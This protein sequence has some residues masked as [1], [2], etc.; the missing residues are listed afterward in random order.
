MAV[1]VRPGT[2][3]HSMPTS[4]MSSAVPS[5]P[6][7]TLHGYLFALVVLVPAWALSFASNVWLGPPFSALPFVMAIVLAAGAG[8][9]NP[10]L[11]ASFITL[12]IVYLNVRSPN[13][14]L[15]VSRGVL[16]LVFLALLG[17]MIS[18]L[19]EMLHRYRREAL[20]QARFCEEAHDAIFAWELEG[21]VRYWNRAADELY[22]FNR[23]LFAEVKATLLTTGQWLGELTHR[24]SDGRE[25][26]V[27]SRM[28]LIRDGAELTVVEADR[29]V[30]ERMH[31]LV[32]LREADRRK[33]EFL[34]TLAHEIRNPLAPIRNELEIMRVA[35]ADPEVV[36]RSRAVMERQLAHL[37]HLVDDLMD[38][39]R[40]TRGKLEL[41]RERLSLDA[42]LQA[43]LETS[44][45][46]IEA[47]HHSFVPDMPREPLYVL[48]DLTR[49]AQLFSN[50][51]NNAAKYTP[52]GGRITLTAKRLDGDAVV[53][54]RDSGVGIAVEAL[55]DIFEMFAQANRERGL[56]HGGL[57]IGLALVHGIAEMHGGTVT[58]ASDGVG[59][60]S[61]FT[62]R[63]PA[64]EVDAQEVASAQPADLSPTVTRRRVLVADDNLDAAESLTMLLTMMGHEVRAAHDGAQAVDQ[65]EQFRPDLILMDVGMPKLDGLQ[66]AS[67]IRSFAWGAAPVIVALTGWGQDADR[68]RSK[69]AGCDEHFVKPLDIDRLTELLAHLP[70]RAA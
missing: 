22:G 44:R 17:V 58:A 48:G 31:T 8:G 28:R 34:A 36:E 54:V 66:A 30:T 52:A 70:V 11:L 62:V 65:A 6:L 2:D 55:P 43:A 41:R 60:G 47:A 14:T 3:S 24:T 51:L 4:R 16:T 12:A 39:S 63:L 23:E 18:A 33:D 21:P 53:E 1:V 46:L 57:G 37:V 64:L 50:L 45:P 26:R 10:G 68:Q 29:D 19:C 15:P 32:T 25:V 20:R 38:V 69:A 35:R 61:T 5:L 49:L 67:K 56:T 59:L 13:W 9:L 27:E 42:A 7:P 40:I